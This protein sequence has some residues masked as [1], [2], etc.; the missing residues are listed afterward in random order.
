MAAPT[1]AASGTVTSDGTEQTLATITT[2]GAYELHVDHGAMAN[3]EVVRVR[4]K[5]AVLSGGTSRAV[6]YEQYSATG[7]ATPEPPIRKIGPVA[8]NN[9]G[10]FTLERTS[11]SARAHPWKILRVA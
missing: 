5:E 10:T 2:P 6:E 11:G 8:L 4:V 9:G 7:S 1:V 3:T